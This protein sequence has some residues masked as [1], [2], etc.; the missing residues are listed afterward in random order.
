MNLKYTELYW[1][2]LEYTHGF[3]QNLQMGDNWGIIRHWTQILELVL[4]IY[5]L[6]PGFYNIMSH[7]VKDYYWI[8]LLYSLSAGFTYIP[9]GIVLRKYFSYTNVTHVH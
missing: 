8:Y 4:V 3:I 1:N 7:S 2:I 6:P 9:Q 5:S